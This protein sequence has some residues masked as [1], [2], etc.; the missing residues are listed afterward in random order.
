[1]VLNLKVDKINQ[2]W[3]KWSKVTHKGDGTAILHKPE[4]FGPVLADCSPLEATGHILLD[5]TC[6]FLVIIPKPYTVKLSWDKLLSQDTTSVKFNK[7]TL[8]DAELGHLS[9][10]TDRDFILLDCKGHTVEEE[11]RGNYKM[12]YRAILYNS[13]MIPYDFSK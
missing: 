6:H 2:M 10:L 8:E 11:S 12:S 1:M 4:F 7:I 5:L 9:K 3:I 13:N